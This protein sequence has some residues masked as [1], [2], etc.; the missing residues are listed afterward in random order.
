MILTARKIPVGR[1]NTMTI[2]NRNARTKSP[3]PLLA[4]AGTQTAPAWLGIL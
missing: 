2:K 1:A 3:L 4:F